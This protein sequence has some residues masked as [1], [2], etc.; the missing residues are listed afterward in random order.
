[1][2][3]NNDVNP[4]SRLGFFEA[5]YLGK[6]DLWRYLLVFLAV[7]LGVAIGQIP[8]A[9]MMIYKRVPDFGKFNEDDTAIDFSALGLDTNM[10]LFLMLLGFVGGL[11]ML[12]VMVKWVHQRSWLT[13]INFRGKIRLERLAFGFSFWLFLLFLFE[14]FSYS[15]SPGDYVFSFSGIH[16]FGL[17]LIAIFILPLQTSAEE[18]FFRGWLMQ[19]IGMVG[20]S[21]IFAL[22]LTSVFFCAVHSSNPEIAAYGFLPMMLMYLQ[23]GLFLGLITIL[24]DSLEMALGAHFATNFFVS[25]FFGYENAALQTH[26]FFMKEGDMDVIM[27]NIGFFIAAALFI[28]VATYI[29]RWD[30]RR[31]FEPINREIDNENHTMRSHSSKD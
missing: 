13:L 3:L 9:L 27:S 25:V 8:L 2:N 11:I 7:I 4:S 1:M 31:L 17:L 23:A 26:S 18:L 5:V 30:F 21:K 14:V 29:Y 12:I 10:G 19:G 20:K 6:N 28:L 16:F 24:D 22:L 15:F